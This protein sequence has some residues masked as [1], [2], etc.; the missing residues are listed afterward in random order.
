MI[1]VNETILFM[2][3]AYTITTITH[4]QNSSPLMAIKTLKQMPFQW[5]YNSII[6][7]TAIGYVI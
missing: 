5:L 1:Y 3:I 6:E 2:Y 4:W 7:I